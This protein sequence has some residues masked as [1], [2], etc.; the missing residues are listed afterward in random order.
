MS[1]LNSPR[2]Q[3]PWFRKMSVYTILGLIKGKTT[4]QNLQMKDDPNLYQM[5][6]NLNI[7]ANGRGPQ[8][9]GQ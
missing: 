2:R 8:L 4:K 6:D 1:Y 7:L 5:E 9:F 3:S